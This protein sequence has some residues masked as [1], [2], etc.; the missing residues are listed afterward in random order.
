MEKSLFPCRNRIKF[1]RFLACDFPTSFLLLGYFSLW[2]LIYCLVFIFRLASGSISP[3]G[4]FL[5]KRKIK[6]NPVIQEISKTLFSARNS[7][8]L[9][10]YEQ[11][12]IFRRKRKISNLSSLVVA[13]SFYGRSYIRY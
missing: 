10:R 12:K 2:V 3:R 11:T 1:L 13:V 6:K 9:A 8:R 4:Y 7:C 5:S